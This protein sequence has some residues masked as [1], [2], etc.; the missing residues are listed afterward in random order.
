MEK[1]KDQKVEYAVLIHGKCICVEQMGNDNW[2]HYRDY[3]AIVTLFSKWMELIK[4]SKESLDEV[5]YDLSKEYLDFSAKDLQE[6]WSKI[7]DIRIAVHV[8]LCSIDKEKYSH[9][10]EF[11]PDEWVINRIRELTNS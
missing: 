8:Y 11:M 2:K 5:T 4:P 7:E 1:P 9:F 6:E 10:D 3:K